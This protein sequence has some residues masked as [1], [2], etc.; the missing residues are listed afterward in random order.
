MK[1]TTVHQQKPR[2]G[3]DARQ[4]LVE[5]L[6]RQAITLATMPEHLLRVLERHGRGALAA[7]LRRQTRSLE[8]MTARLGSKAA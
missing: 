4:A 7:E 5:E 2:A 6:H 8:A 1:R 3:T